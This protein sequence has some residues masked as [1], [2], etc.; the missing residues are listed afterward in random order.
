M[1]DCFAIQAIFA[2]ATA[3]AGSERIAETFYIN[4][5]APQLKEFKKVLS[6]PGVLNPRPPLLLPSTKDKR[7]KEELMQE[8]HCKDDNIMVNAVVMVK[9]IFCM[10]LRAG[11]CKNL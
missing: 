1:L 4:N 11:F 10:F 5:I 2:M 3:S 8:T 9:V 6:I 7:E